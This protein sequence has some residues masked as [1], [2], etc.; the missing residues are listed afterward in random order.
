M[1]L[2]FG[3]KGFVLLLQVHKLCSRIAVRQILIANIVLALD[4]GHVGSSCKRLASFA[5]AR[6]QATTVAAG[7]GGRGWGRGGGGAGEQGRERNECIGREETL[8]PP[9]YG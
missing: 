4:M 9:W 7:C 3:A 6:S 1:Y 8:N 5:S 2:G